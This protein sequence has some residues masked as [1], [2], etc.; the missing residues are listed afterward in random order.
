MFRV[1]HVADVHLGKKFRKLGEKGREQRQQIRETFSNVIQKAIDDNIQ[2]VLFAGDIF[3]SEKPFEGD[4]QFFLSLLKKLS[5]AGIYSC[6][7]AGNHDMMHE[8]SPYA[9]KELL[10]LDNV[11]VFTK[12][13]YV[14]VISEFDAAVY[15][16]SCYTKKSTESPFFVFKEKKEAKYQIG[17]IHGSF[18]IPEKSSPDAYP[19]TTEEIAASGFDYV[20][21]GDWHSYQDYS[22]GDV[23]AFYSGAPEALDF[24][25]SGAGF[26]N[27]VTFNHET[28]V[29]K[30]RV[31]RREF[32]KVE[33]DVT[34]VEDVFSH[35]LKAVLEVAGVDVICEVKLFGMLSLNQ[36]F[37][38]EKLLEECGDSFFELILYDET[39]VELGDEKL[40]EFDEDTVVGVFVKHMKEKVEQ[41]SGDDEKKVLEKALQ[42]GVSKLMGK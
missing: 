27:V 33:I 18:V 17:I 39:E 10:N 19:F 32:T 26:V 24:D 3:D 28:V 13:N 29:E 21:I 5:D 23:K 30:V 8:H 40:S 31:G 6:M 2:I 22:V 11:I 35:V 14:H 42:F 4:F 16:A 37:S 34:G 38:R 20:A 36:M 12:D 41:A 25:Q 9:R 7:I 15:G 1:L